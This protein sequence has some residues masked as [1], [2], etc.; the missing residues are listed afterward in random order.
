MFRKVQFS[1][2]ALPRAL[3]FLKHL[4]FP[5]DA[6]SLI[7]LQLICLTDGVVGD[8]KDWRW[9]AR[10]VTPNGFRCR[11]LSVKLIIINN[12]RSNDHRSLKS[13]LS[14]LKMRPICVA[15]IRQRAPLIIHASDRSFFINHTRI[16]W[17]ENV[18]ERKRAGHPR[19]LQWTRRR[20]REL[21]SGQR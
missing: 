16:V 14:I 1:M 6:A 17:Q 11:A 7:K 21:V 4:N 2:Q 13:I 20:C 8:W 18:R 5:V 15:A 9:V 3:A 19:A 12:E 10:S